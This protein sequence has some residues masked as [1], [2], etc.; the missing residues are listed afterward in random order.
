MPG[1][2]EVHTKSTNARIIHG[3]LNK[4]RLYS[5]RIGFACGL[6]YKTKNIAN[7]TYANFSTHTIYMYTQLVSQLF[8]IE[9]SCV[10][11]L[12]R[13]FMFLVA[14]GGLC[15]TVYSS[16]TFFCSFVDRIREGGEDFIGFLQK[17]IEQMLF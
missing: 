16:L 4:M 2:I 12:P 5:L 7:V 9:F 13:F 3:G 10:F 15:T 8:S 17:L 6:R 1:C 14:L 11:A